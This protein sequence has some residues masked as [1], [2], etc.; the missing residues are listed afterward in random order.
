[1]D[2]LITAC[3]L[4]LEDDKYVF[5]S[6]GNYIVVLE[7]LDDTRTNELRTNISDPKYA[8][9]RANK[10]KVLLIIHKFD[11]SN[12]LEKVENSYYKKKVVYITNEIIEIDDY[13]YDLNVVGTRGIHYFKTIE[14]AFFWELL[15]FNP[16]HTGKWIERYENGNKKSEGEYKQGRLEG[17]RIEWYENGNKKSEGGFKEG[18]QEG[19]WIV[20]Y[21]N[22][23][24][25]SEGGFKEGKKEGEWIEWYENGLVLAGIK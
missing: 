17:K 7:K 4:Y 24:K 10:L 12:I 5:K 11:P 1:M 9:Y 8:K 3:K 19:K 23:N 18:K 25:K 2:D 20:W 21:E 14:Q 6:C 15:K 22:G 13:D 16:A